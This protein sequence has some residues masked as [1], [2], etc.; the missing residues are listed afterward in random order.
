MLDIKTLFFVVFLIQAFLTLVLFLYWKTQK[1][2]Q[3]FFEWI[4]A[5]FIISVTTFIFSF[6]DFLPDILTIP[7]GTLSILYI[8]LMLDALKLFFTKRRLRR[9]IYLIS[10]LSI[11]I[12]YYFTEYVENA[13]IRNIIVLV[14]TIIVI[15]LIINVLLTKPKSGERYFSRFMLLGYVLLMFTIIL[16]LLEWF[17]IPASRNLFSSSTFNI[18][19]L[20]AIL[21][22][23]LTIHL[24]FIL[25]NFQRT[26]QELYEAKIEAQNIADRYSLAASS[27]RAGLWHMDLKTGIVHWDDSLEKLLGSEIDVKTKLLEIWNSFEIVKE[28]ESNPEKKC[29]QSVDSTLLTTEFTLHHK[30]EGL[31]HFMVHA[32]IVSND[33]NSCIVIGLIYDDTPLRKTENAL[34]ETNKKLNLLN[35]I[36]RHDI[37]NMVNGVNGFAAILMSQLDDPIMRENAENIAKC[38]VMIQ[39]LISFTEHYQNLGAKEPLWQDICFLLED[40]EIKSITEGKIL[41]SPEPGI[42]IY[43]DWMLK[44]VLYNLIENSLRHGGDV[45]SFSFSYDFSK[46]GLAVVYQDDGIGIPEENK[47]KIFEKDYGKNTGLGLFFCREVLEITG[48]KIHE[49]GVYGKGA[50]FEIIVPVGSFRE[51]NQHID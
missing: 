10:V 48:L 13:M 42:Q 29:S 22:A 14:S 46:D 36:T 24:S 44:K 50:R 17:Q 23:I 25:L 28:Y 20:L 30:K 7:T 27:A 37:L 31:L 16:R 26:A 15:S 40:D 8:V 38:G 41:K 35:S 33:A 34:K 11:I 3:G 39:H 6:S 32:H 43:A 51:V 47:A 1:T 18:L 9:E 2:Y 5:L 21:V 12:F 19:L 49:N 45:S 4:L